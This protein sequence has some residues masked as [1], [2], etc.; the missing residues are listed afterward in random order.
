MGACKFTY[1][2]SASRSKQ[3]T[4]HRSFAKKATGGKLVPPPPPRCYRHGDSCN[5]NSVAADKSNVYGQRRYINAN[6]DAT[7]DTDDANKSWRYADNTAKAKAEAD[8]DVGGG[9]AEFLV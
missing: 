3:M 5:D 2:E 7:K 1:D 9:D 6:N 4:I 8:K